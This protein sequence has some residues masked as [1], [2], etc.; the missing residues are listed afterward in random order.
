MS[1]EKK[2]RFK[3]TSSFDANDS[4]GEKNLAATTQ[5]KKPITEVI[6]LVPNMEPA[7]EIVVQFVYCWKKF[8]IFIEFIMLSRC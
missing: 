4:S 7:F 3:D 5:K 8:V 2:E 1:E 6:S